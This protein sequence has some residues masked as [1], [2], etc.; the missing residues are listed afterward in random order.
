MYFHAF[1]ANGED[2]YMAGVEPGTY[3]ASITRENR[4]STNSDASTT[5]SA[6][7]NDIKVSTTLTK[8]NGGYDTYT[9]WTE[10]SLS[11]VIWSNGRPGN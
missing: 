1:T 7:L 2:L 10:L 5:E 11:N 3:S 9:G 4:S 8:G 6:T